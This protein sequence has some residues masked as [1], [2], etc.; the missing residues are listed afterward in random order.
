[1]RLNIKNT[2]GDCFDTEFVTESGEKLSNI[3]TADITFR[4][5]HAVVAKLQFLVPNVDCRAEATVSEE[6]LRALASAHGFDLV[7]K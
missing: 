2:T 6:H 4:P 7:K 5:N 1:M 3:A